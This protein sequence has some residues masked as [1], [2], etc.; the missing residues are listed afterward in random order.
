MPINLLKACYLI[1]FLLLFWNIITP[2]YAILVSIFSCFAPISIIIL[3]ITPMILLTLFLKEASS[4]VRILYIS[5]NLLHLL[6]LQIPHHFMIYYIMLIQCLFIRC[7]H[8][9]SFIIIQKN[10]DQPINEVGRNKCFRM[11]L[12]LLKTL[13]ISLYNIKTE[14]NRRLSLCHS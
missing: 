3:S 6:L 13:Q 11:I 1:I 9:S 4:S 12:P 10:Y 8:Q 2:T 5:L 7:L 14:K